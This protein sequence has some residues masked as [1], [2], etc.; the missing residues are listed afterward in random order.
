MA[1]TVIEAGNAVLA[2]MA[3]AAAR[4]PLTEEE[5]ALYDAE[6]RRVSGMGFTEFEIYLFRSD[7]PGIAKEVDS[8]ETK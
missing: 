2:R 4:K 3:L 7:D 5:I 1:R 6:L 8:G